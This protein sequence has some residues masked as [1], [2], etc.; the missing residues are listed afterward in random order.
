MLAGGRAPRRRSSSSS[1][2]HERAALSVRSHNCIPQRLK[3]KTLWFHSYFLSATVCP[4]V[5]RHPLRCHSLKSRG[6]CSRYGSSGI[7]VPFMVFRETVPNPE[8]RF[9]LTPLSH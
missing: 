8:C 4:T 6:G 1:G 7:V 5:C 3:E 2:S 9:K